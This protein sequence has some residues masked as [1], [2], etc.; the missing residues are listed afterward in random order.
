MRLDKQLG[1]DPRLGVAWG[2]LP[3]DVQVLADPAVPLPKGVQLAPTYGVRAPGKLALAPLLGSLLFVAP[4]FTADLRVPRAPI[5]IG[6]ALIYAVIIGAGLWARGRGRAAEASDWR[7]GWFLLDR[8]VLVREGG[9]ASWFPV[10]A[11]GWVTHQQ[12]GG[13][14]GGMWAYSGDDSVYVGASNTPTVKVGFALEATVGGKKSQ[15]LSRVAVT[16]QAINDVEFW[17]HKRQLK[18]GQRRSQ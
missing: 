4:L 1:T 9:R 15:H 16:K 5:L 11:I 7:Q 17:A 10:D 14:S 2:T 13:S 3:D 6:V 8:G 18:K 12:S